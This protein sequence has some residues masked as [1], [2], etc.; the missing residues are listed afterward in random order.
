MTG[1]KR[2]CSNCNTNL[3]SEQLM[4]V[5]HLEH[6]HCFLQD[7]TKRFKLNYEIIVCLEAISL[8]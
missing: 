8:L 7:P 1:K 5:W 4:A 6:A 2:K 3:E